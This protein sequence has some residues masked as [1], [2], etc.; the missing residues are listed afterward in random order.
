MSNLIKKCLT[1]VFL[2]A[3]AIFMAFVF[4]Y[5]IIDKANQSVF[6]TFQTDSENLVVSSIEAGKS[7]QALNGTGWV[8]YQSSYGLQGL[9]FNALSKIFP[10]SAESIISLGH[11]MASGALAVTI[12]AICFLLWRYYSPVFAT[13]FYAVSLLSPWMVIMARNLYW[14]EFTLFLP[15]LVGCLYYSGLLDSKKELRYGLVFTVILIKSLCGYE[16]VTC[17]MVSMMTFPFLKMAQQKSKDGFKN[18]FKT[19]AIMSVI[20]VS[21]LATGIAIHALRVG[22]GN[23]SEGFAI[24]TERMGYRSFAADE[25]TINALVGENSEAARWL[26]YTKNVPL[27]QA[28]KTYFTFDTQIIYGISGS[29]FIPLVTAAFT[30][31][32]IYAVKKDFS[33]LVLLV[34]FMAGTLSW[35]V[36]FKPHVMG[37]TN[38]CYIIWYTGFAQTCFYCLVKPLE[39]F[40]PSCKKRIR[41]D[42]DI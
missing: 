3:A 40:L 21:A 34:L 1:A 22:G 28:I 24:V 15:L 26:L 12:A 19:L 10:L 20:A 39:L 5:N 13:V 11:K 6:D 14:V 37:H 23:L 42:I 30:V 18:E 27:I 8:S 9:F 33:S 2:A 17:A 25:G 16:F 31:A 41:S 32:I 4:N 36:L 35:I 38:I 29:F 7:G